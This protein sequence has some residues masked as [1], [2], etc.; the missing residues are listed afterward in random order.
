[1]WTKGTRSSQYPD[2]KIIHHSKDQRTATRECEKWQVHTVRLLHPSSPG[3]G[4]KVTRWAHPVHPHSMY[5]DTI[6]K[7]GSKGLRGY[8]EASKKVWPFMLHIMIKILESYMYHRQE[9]LWRQVWKENTWVVMFLLTSF[10]G[11]GTW[12]TWRYSVCCYV[13]NEQ[14]HAWKFVMIDPEF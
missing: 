11:E 10:S 12:D 8:L 3:A 1:M 4:S 7:K 6:K 5:A 9:K 2:K 13:F 14:F